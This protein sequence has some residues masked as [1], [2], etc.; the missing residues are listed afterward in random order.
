V[1]SNTPIYTIVIV[2][3]TP[4]IVEL[5]V[6]VLSDDPSYQPLAARDGPAAIELLTEVRADLVILDVDLPGLSGLEVYDRLQA[7]PANPPPPVLFIT[8]NGANPAFQQRRFPHY[9]A[10]PFDLDDLL[11]WIAHLLGRWPKAPEPA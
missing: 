1:P 5:I 7:D 10:K 9:L 8:A 2:D 4:A 11:A 6:D 3:D